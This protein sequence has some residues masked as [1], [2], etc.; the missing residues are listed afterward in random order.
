MVGLTTVFSTVCFVLTLDKDSQTGELLFN[1]ESV[2][3][4]DP[5]HGRYSTVP[6]RLSLALDN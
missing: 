5:Q 6:V 2:V 3:Y 1:L 4:K